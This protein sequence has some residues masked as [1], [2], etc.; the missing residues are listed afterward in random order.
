MDGEHKKFLENIHKEIVSQ[1]KSITSTI[2]NLDLSVN[3]VVEQE[4]KGMLGNLAR[5]LE[6]LSGGTKD[7][8]KEILESMYQQQQEQFGFMQQSTSEQEFRDD[9]NDSLI[10]KVEVTN[11]PEGGAA[12]DDG[13][14]GSAKVDIDKKGGGLLKKLGI[15]LK[16]LGMGLLALSN[17]AL[18]I[19]VAVL[20]AFI[21]AVG[22]AIGLVA[23]FVGADI[24]NFIKALLMAIADGIVYFIQQLSENKKAVMDVIDLFFYFV[25]GIIE[26]FEKY[27][28]IVFPLVKEILQMFLDM[29]PDLIKAVTPLVEVILDFVVEITEALTPI[30]EIIAGLIKDIVTVI[31]ENIPPILEALTPIIE[32]ITKFIVDLVTAIL[33]GVTKIIDAVS[34]LITALTDGISKIIVRNK[35]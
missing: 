24:A 22:L 11:W 9:I 28:A 10:Q 33:D 27:V 12:A 29:L 25:D 16:F 30:I 35:K 3:I 19:G 13:G 34:G 31:V 18:F 5:T 4:K 17:P 14:G 15:G 23:K 26:A 1:G 21:L 8:S 20:A 7:S 32:I 6:S 2:D